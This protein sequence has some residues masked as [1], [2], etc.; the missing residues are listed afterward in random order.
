[1]AEMASGLAPFARSSLHGG[2]HRRAQVR[3]RK[4]VRRVSSNL[5]FRSE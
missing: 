3:H 5:V 1:M 4:L 2:Y